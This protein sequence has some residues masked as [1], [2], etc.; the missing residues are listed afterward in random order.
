[1]SNNG[2]RGRFS[3]RLKKIRR[4]RTR[5]KQSRIDDSESIQ[6]NTD[7][8]RKGLLFE[9][10]FFS[11]KREDKKR[12]NA[13]ADNNVLKAIENVTSNIDIDT[14][15]RN[16]VVTKGY[17]TTSY[18][19]Y[20]RHTRN[21]RQIIAKTN[22]NNW[23]E[24]T[25]DNNKYVYKTID[26]ININGEEH[27]LS[28]KEKYFLKLEKDILDL[29]KKR[30][31]KNVNELEMLQSDLYII[32]QINN[33]DDY[34]LECEENVKEIKK[35]ISKVKSLKEK[36]DYL[37]D[38]FDFEYLLGL[39][40]RLLADKI[41]E[42]KEMYSSDQISDMVKEYKIY[43]EYKYLYDKIDKL[44]V[45]ANKYEK[46]KEQKVVE[47]KN[48]GIDFEKFKENV[49]DVD[50]INESY[51]S[52]VK[53]QQKFLDELD[54]KI[55]NIDSYEEIEYRLKGFNKLLGNSFKYMGLLLLSP[56][57]GLLP[58]I[59]TETLITKN[60]LKNLYNNLEWEENKKMKYTAIDYSN[61]IKF[62]INNVN[63]V[64]KLVDTTLTDIVKL[65][66]EFN[67][68]FQ[69]HCYKYP[70]YQE[71]IKKLNKIENMIV[72]NKVKLNVTIEKLKQ[73]EKIN[74]NKMIRVKKLNEEA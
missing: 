55:A 71:T 37:K 51:V 59:A 20:K 62:A 68:K 14:D 21:K 6:N 74:E 29:I 9:L 25:K 3:E 70:E 22:E 43:D 52:F 33:N 72:G 54:E 16:G 35:M 8:G 39:D 64:S 41:L 56:F 24:E 28:D 65:K 48:R 34:L 49:V 47:L 61:S 7:S 45:E 36:Y 63:D 11:N 2:N 50:K 44:E 42:L 66:A 13:N 15:N 30:L 38:N 27:V 58:Y 57:K 1:M 17:D 12:T 23:F 40:D 46:Y 69:E 18:V 5:L 10:L 60:N 31:I 19:S 73:R 32:S 26:S 67:K 53:K 4:D